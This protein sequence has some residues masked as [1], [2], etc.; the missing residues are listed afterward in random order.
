M[1]VRAG[2]AAVLAAVLAVAGCSAPEPRWTEVTL[3][4]T[5]PGVFRDAVHCGGHWYVVG[6]LQPPGGDPSPAAWESTDGRAW[7]S[8]R[9]SPAPGSYYGPRQVIYSVACADGRIAALGAQS[10]G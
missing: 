4:A 5:Q 8:V 6:A 9:I 7:R 10:G 2:A 1:S 3:P